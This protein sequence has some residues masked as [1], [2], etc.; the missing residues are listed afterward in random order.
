MACVDVGMTSGSGTGQA[1]KQ[2]KARA[3]HLASK[4]ASLLGCASGVSV[5]NIEHLLHLF[6]VLVVA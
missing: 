1:I 3:V 5:D 2:G 6:D 4:G